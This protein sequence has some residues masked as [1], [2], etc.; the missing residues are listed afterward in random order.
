M[1]PQRSL[2]VRLALTVVPV[3]VLL[4]ASARLLLPG[5]DEAV[6]RKMGEQSLLGFATANVG[7]FAIGVMPFVQ[8][9]AVVE[10]VALAVPAMRRLRHGNPEGRAKLDRASRALGLLLAAFQAFGIAVQLRALS[11]SD[12]VMTASLP[13]ISV[14]VVTATLVGG[15]CLSML[16][17]DLV[18]RQGIVNGLLLLPC[19]SFVLATIDGAR[20]GV[21]RAMTAGT[22]EPRHWVIL[23]GTAALALLAGWAATRGVHDVRAN[24]APAE[25]RT[26][27][28]DA[29]ALVVTPWVPV[30]SSS[31]AP[32]TIA[33]S[34]LMLPATLMSFNLPLK[35][36]VA[37][38]ERG[39]LPFTISYVA[40]MAALVFAFTRLLHRPAEAEDLARRLGT[41]VD[42][43]AI[44]AAQNRALVP[45]LMFFAV[46]ILTTHAAGR[47]KFLH[48]SVALLP[49][50]S[51][52]AIDAA[53]SIRLPSGFVGVWQERRAAAVPVVR[54]VLEAR[55]IDTRVTGA[56]TN[57]LFQAFAPYAA[58]TLHVPSAD[59]ER[60]TKIL[61]HLLLGEDAPEPAPGAPAEDRA[62]RE[63]RAG[64]TVR[65]RAIAL[66]VMLIA[67]LGLYGLTFKT[68]PPPPLRTPAKLEVVPVADTTEVF[69]Q[70][71]D[72]RVP[73]GIELRRE[74]VSTGLDERGARV[75]S[76]RTFAS[77]TLEQGETLDHAI[78][79][80][81]AWVAST[82]VLPP[83]MR[84]AW[85]PVYDWNEE[86]GTQ[87][88]T[89]ARTYVLEGD[90]WLSNRDV[91]DAEA[92]ID[93]RSGMPEVYVAITLAEQGGERFRVLTAERINQRIAILLDGRVN[94]A[95]VVRTEIGGGRISI[96][97]GA[98]DPDKQLKTAQSLAAGLRQH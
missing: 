56:A 52:L 79:R 27:Y 76:Q 26:A 66:G 86:S 84:V 46:L 44:L 30:P 7:V 77:V 41:Q 50:A 54:A 80:G 45:S 32:Y 58:V 72:D 48:L 10:L 64:W 21:T 24:D 88:L 63:R 8:A 5:L 6:V 14:P 38:L 98:G 20:D 65:T 62:N 53:R 25:E 22:W 43:S 85:E 18:T 4:F 81:D 93:Q 75:S 12:F 29:R 59:A 95:P 17:A 39:D 42:R 83:R 23:V 9:Y 47:V 78:A 96:T 40:V 19:V 68:A 15:A 31:I 37:T 82:I 55:G 35:G 61:R 67:G 1:K 90:S 13:P 57:A 3:V 94:S 16:V 34:I 92:S 28:R 74:N 2:G 97:M 87:T 33:A 51:A 36:I 11:S 73:A 91:V 89:G 60:A 70:V 49:L 71:P 69:G